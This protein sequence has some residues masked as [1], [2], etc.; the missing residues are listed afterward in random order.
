M[1]STPLWIAIKIMLESQECDHCYGARDGEG[2]T[3][4]TG[5]STPGVNASLK[6]PEAFYFLTHVKSTNALLDS[7]PQK[8]SLKWR[9][10]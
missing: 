10:S 1:K 9:N 7:L 2:K 4:A 6:L 8:C 5:L 3:V